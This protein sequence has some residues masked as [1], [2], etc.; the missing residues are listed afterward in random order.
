MEFHRVKRFLVCDGAQA[1]IFFRRIADS[2]AFCSGAMAGPL[3]TA[4]S[5]ANCE[6]WH[7]QSQHCSVEFQWTWQPRCVQTAEFRCSLPFEVAAGGD[8]AACPS[9]MMPPSPGLSSSIEVELAG[10]QIFGEILDRRHVLADVIDDARRRLA[11][12]S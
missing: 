12:G 9:R 6:P 5:G 11:A 3:S 4:P 8:L 10:H 7:G 1:L 2:F